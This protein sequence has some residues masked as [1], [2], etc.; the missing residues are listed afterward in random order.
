M[1]PVQYWPALK[2]LLDSGPGVVLLD[3]SVDRSLTAGAR[4]HPAVRSG[5]SHIVPL[6]A[7]SRTTGGSADTAAF[8]AALDSLALLSAG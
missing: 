4:R 6:L 7:S 1:F 2:S 5:A 8:A 3:A